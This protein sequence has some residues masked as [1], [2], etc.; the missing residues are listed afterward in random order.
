MTNQEYENARNA[1]IP[2]AERIANEIISAEETVRGERVLKAER[3]RIFFRTM[4]ALAEADRL[5]PPGNL[6]LFDFH[7]KKYAQSDKEETI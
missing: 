7:A 6:A 1:L 3:V 2:K 5:I 4:T